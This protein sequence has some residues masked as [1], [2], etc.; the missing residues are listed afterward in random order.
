M[1]GFPG[2]SGQLAR[3]SL[4][5]FKLYFSAST[6][7][8]LQE[9]FINSLSSLLEFNYITSFLLLGFLKMFCIPYRSRN[10]DQLRYPTLFT[11]SSV[12]RHEYLS[13][14]RTQLSSCSGSILNVQALKEAI[15]I[16]FGGQQRLGSP[17]N[18][19]LL[20]SRVM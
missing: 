17:K 4:Q 3:F 11:L 2:E 18:V 6:A 16:Y 10:L 13:I 9:V 19:F 7:S 14:K 20:S 15:D 1:A 5:L 12:T 8:K